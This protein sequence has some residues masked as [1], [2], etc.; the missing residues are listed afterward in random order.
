MKH[1]L[2]LLLFSVSLV[3]SAAG[4]SGQAADARVVKLYGNQVNLTALSRA[5]KIEAFR[6]K[7]TIENAEDKRRKQ[8]RG[9]PV[10]SGPH[11]LDKD[12]ARNLV[13]LLQRKSTYDF[14]RDKGCEMVPGVVVVFTHQRI[15][16]E[17]VLCFECDQLE[18]FV[19]DKNTG[20]EDFDPA[21]PQLVK[22]VKQ[23]FPKDRAIQ[24]LKP[25]A[26]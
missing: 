13:R 16:V 1:L 4:E 17:L 11:S 19:G 20:Y 8:I 23:I 7:H 21:R 26:R 5:E 22:L 18:I 6:I 2:V 10:L 9:Y 24:A 25:M 3:F 12:V 15:K 14:E